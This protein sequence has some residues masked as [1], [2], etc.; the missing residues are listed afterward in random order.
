MTGQ[1]LSLPVANLYL[2]PD[3]VGRRVSYVDRL[4]VGMIS[5]RV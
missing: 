4:Q 5:A 1:S 3:N 2:A